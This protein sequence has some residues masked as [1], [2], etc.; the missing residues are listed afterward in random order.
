MYMV[1]KSQECLTA[2]KIP[3]N[4]VHA[5]YEL[6]TYLTHKAMRQSMSTIYSSI[7]KINN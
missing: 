6:G 7:V 5:D 3:L 1:D 4:L 2:E